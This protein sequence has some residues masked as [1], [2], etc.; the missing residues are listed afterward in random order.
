[1]IAADIRAG[2]AI[3]RAFQKREPL[4][5][6]FFCSMV[7]QAEKSGN[8]GPVF[9]KLSEYYEKRLAFQKKITRLL[10]YPLFIL[11]G[12]SGCFI[13]LLLF[14]VP[15]GLRNV[16]ADPDNLSIVTKTAVS[17]AGF[18]QTHALDAVVLSAIIMVLI[19]CL[20]RS[21]LK[22]PWFSTFAW[23]I[24]VAGDVLRKNSLQRFALSLSALLSSGFDPAH[25]LTISAAE[26]RN[27]PL[28][29]RILHALIDTISGPG[30]I[31]SILKKL[32]IFPPFIIEMAINGKN[33]DHSDK[34]LKKI[35][36]FYQDEVEAAFNAFAII[37]G[38]VFVMVSGLLGI[39]VI[40][41]LYLPVLKLVGNH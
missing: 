38:P 29:K 9:L 35:A 20:W 25:A 12:T 17:A 31:F 22:S 8:P 40:V 24:P 28:E 15:M 41:S 32:S 19:Y 27:I 30:P 23:R 21:N 7:I 18:I 13:T 26:L 39:G 3:S 37:I 33:P 4:F 16:L 14:I 11:L 36:A 6:A 10:K 34:H 5:G 2:D 1:M